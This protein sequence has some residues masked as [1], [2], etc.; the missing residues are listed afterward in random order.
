[1]PSAQIRFDQ[2]S[3]SFRGATNQM[4]AK[5]RDGM[6]SQLLLQSL[7]FAIE[8]G[9]RVAIV[10]PTGAGKTSLL[11]LLN[12]L[13]EATQGSIY[14]E[15][16]DIRQI[17]VTELRQKI[18]LVLQESRLLGLT[19]RDTLA[20]PLKLQNLSHQVI[21]EQVSH[22]VEQLSIPGEWLDRMEVQLSLGQRQWVSI[23]R[24]LI[25]HPTVL[26]LD[27]PTSALDLGKSTSLVS[28]LKTLSTRD[29]LTVV[30]VNHQ[31]EV[32]QEFATHI[33]YLH[34]GKLQRDVPAQEV[35]WA[36]LRQTILNAEVQEAEEWS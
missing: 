7:S 26:L 14:Y 13:V 27:E 1:M 33:L 15:D 17:P 11:R 29:A 5:G 22:W 20:Y 25:L 3:L 30:M 9:D 8:R 36:E 24:A 18:T 35:D 32:V 21:Q 2:V 6:D 34:Q 12:R 16:Q 31:L 4:T 23:A 10:G 28:L 19:V